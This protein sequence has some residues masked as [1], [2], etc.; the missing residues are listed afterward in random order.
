MPGHANYAPCALDDLVNK[1]YD[2]WALAHVHQAA[3]LHENP[4]VV[5][6]GNLQG[7]QIR[8]A[9][10]KSA[11]LVLVEDNQVEEITPVHA[12]VVRWIHLRV[13]VEHCGAV[14]DVIDIVG[15]AIEDAVARHAQG[16]LLACRI[17]VT[18]STALHGRLLGSADEL[19]AEARA[20]ALG[21]G[22]EVAWIE[23]LVIATHSP[24]TATLRKDALGDL[25]RMI[26]GAAQDTSLQAQ[27]ASDLGDLV[28]KLPHDVRSD[29]EDAVLK[30]AIDGDYA[31]L[32]AYVG[33]YLTARLEAREV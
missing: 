13:A 24:N 5:F 15:K 27:L 21:L 8:E 4:H 6:C 11:A 17:E 12:D 23:R 32:I 33:G 28:R 1:G 9:G 7:R 25:Q 31:S 3:V 30:A 10:P 2:Y 20:A 22:E 18:G 16:R 29:A 14:A 26:G 19:L